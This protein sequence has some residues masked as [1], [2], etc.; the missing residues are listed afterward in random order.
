[1]PA[2]TTIIT[3]NNHIE[4]V[5]YVIIYLEQQ[6]STFLE[7]NPTKALRSK[8]I[9]SKQKNYGSYTQNVPN[10]SAFL[11]RRLGGTTYIVE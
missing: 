3:I 11:S 2:T 7:Y 5:K 4:K 8:R 10:L 6:S 1:M 9:V